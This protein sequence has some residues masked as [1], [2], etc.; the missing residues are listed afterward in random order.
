MEKAPE[1]TLNHRAATGRRSLADPQVVGFYHS[2]HTYRHSP[3]EVLDA[4]KE[5]SIREHAGARG[6]EQELIHPNAPQGAISNV[7]DTGTDTLDSSIQD[8]YRPRS[9]YIVRR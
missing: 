9:S 4:S 8:S 3:D 5:S 1:I 6:I 7:G 2:H